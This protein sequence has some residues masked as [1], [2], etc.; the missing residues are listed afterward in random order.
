MK[1]SKVIVVSGMGGSGKTT[2]VKGLIKRYP[3]SKYLSF[4][5][6]DI[7][8]LPFGARYFYAY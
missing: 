2:I 7:D 6:Y 4:D 1:D 8:A 5:D 3:N